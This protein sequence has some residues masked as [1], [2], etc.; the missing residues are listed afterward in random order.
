MEPRERLLAPSVVSTDS[1]RREN[2]NRMKQFASDVFGA[3]ISVMVA[4]SMREW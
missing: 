2:V 1:H 3:I 4:R